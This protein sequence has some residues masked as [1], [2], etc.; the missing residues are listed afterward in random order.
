LTLALFIGTAMSITAVPVISKT[1]MDLGLY[2]TDFGMVIVASAMVNDIIGWILFALVLS[3]L[4]VRSGFGL[5][6]SHTTV[7][8][9]AFVVGM[10]TV[11]RALIHRVLPWIQAHLTW[12]GG[13][14]GA[15]ITLAFFAAA[16]TEASGVHAVLGAFLAGVAIGDSSHLREQT[17]RNISHFISFVFA[18]LFFATIGLRMNFFTNFDL[19]I[20]V[21]V[22]VVACTGKLIGCMAGARLAGMSRREAW[23][24]GIGMNARGTMEI[25]LGTLALES[26]LIS[27]PLF[28]ALIVMALVTAVLPGPALQ[29]LLK[30]RRRAAVVDFLSAKTFTATLA[31]TDR[32]NAIREL[33]VAAADSAGL[34]RNAVR[35]AV[36]KRERAMA[37]GIG[38]GVAVPHA[39]LDRLE[40]PVVAVGVSAAGLD[41]DA[42][43]GQP[44]RVVFLVLT[45]V[46]DDGAQLDILAD[47]S[48]HC[49]KPALV[50]RASRVANCTE[51]LAALKTAES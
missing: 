17:R 39:R 40:K 14:M 16:F 36:L 1:L 27:E 29:F 2:R 34:D 47:I 23:A 44:V 42:P 48:R 7:L 11:G 31:A 37:T 50:E 46:Q 22:L 41:F 10:L 43:D 4:G 24:T 15:A 30:R 5:A 26:G 28:E 9:L 3:T 12:P 8:V 13:V 19:K 25:V 45:S 18:P 32:W 33:A 51:F 49:L 6:V 21:A 38:H 20:V 35:E